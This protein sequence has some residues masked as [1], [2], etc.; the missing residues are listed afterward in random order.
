MLASVTAKVQ[1][2]FGEIMLSNNQLFKFLLN[3]TNEVCGKIILWKECSS[4]LKLQKANRLFDFIYFG[5]PPT[6]P[7]WMSWIGEKRSSFFRFVKTKQQKSTY[8]QFGARYRKIL[9]YPL[10]NERKAP[11]LFGSFLKL[12]NKLFSMNL[13]LTVGLW[14][15]GEKALSFDHF[16]KSFQ[17]SILIKPDT[18][19]PAVL[20]LPVLKA[21][22]RA[23]AVDL[24]RMT[25]LKKKSSLV[26]ESARTRFRCLDHRG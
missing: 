3:F 6:K 17:F 14:K 24:N 12:F 19:V 5:I 25:G 8:L 11:S 10:Q 26:D 2:R 13:L 16:L 4:A 20:C 22:F 15:K 23:P 21:T 18:H 7:L 9:C 1:C